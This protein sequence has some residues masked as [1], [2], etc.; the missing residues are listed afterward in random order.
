[1]ANI[2]IV[3]NSGSGKSTLAKALANELSACHIDLDTLAW[4]HTTPPSRKALNESIS[5]LAALCEPHHY[6]VI[7][8]CYGD[9]ISAF[10]NTDSILVYLDIPLQSCLENA[11]NRPWETHKYP[12]K[13]AQDANLAMLLNWIESYY[14][15]RDDCAKSTHDNLFSAHQGAKLR[16]C[17]RPNINETI[18]RIIGLIT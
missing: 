10:S 3:G 12:S 17:E 4:Q 5:Q 6:A 9:I 1:M 15:R 2:F 18:A 7:E 8:G 11:K 16:I 14:S 13:S